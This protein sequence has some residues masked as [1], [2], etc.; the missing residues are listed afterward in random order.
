MTEG[1]RLARLAVL[2]AVVL[3][4]AL[5]QRGP[6]LCMFRRVTGRPCPSCGMSR[7]WNAAAHLRLADSI[8]FHPLGLP[9]F[10]AALAVALISPE[11]LDGPA[12]RSRRLLAVAGAAWLSVW[13]GRVAG[14]IGQADVSE[15]PGCSR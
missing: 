11:R 1:Q 15:R 6:T 10:V 8:H 5:V 12:L 14:L 2:A 3:P 4:P 9:T 13:L 7:S